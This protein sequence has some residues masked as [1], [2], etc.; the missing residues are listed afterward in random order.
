MTALHTV[1]LAS[2]SNIVRFPNQS[3]VSS[4]RHILKTEYGIGHVKLPRHI[5]FMRKE[6]YPVC[7]GPNFFTFQAEI[8]SKKLADISSRAFAV[9]TQEMI[10]LASEVYGKETGV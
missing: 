10:G 1:C 4:P 3:G 5:Y 6:K 7:G 2:S 8:N 9:N